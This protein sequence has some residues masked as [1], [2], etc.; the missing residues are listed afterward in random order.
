MPVI[1]PRCCVRAHNSGCYYVTPLIIKRACG[2]TLDTS[3]RGLPPPNTP[4]RQCELAP[5]RGPSSHARQKQHQQCRGLPV[6]PAAGLLVVVALGPRVMCIVNLAPSGGMVNQQ[7]VCSSWAEVA[8]VITSFRKRSNKKSV[9]FCYFSFEEKL[10]SST[11]SFKKEV[12][13]KVQPSADVT[14]IVVRG[15]QLCV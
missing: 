7:L 11:T 13:R 2:G 9:F 5:F 12:A 15:L 1:A 4:G 14:S 10:Y 8:L 6:L 3:I